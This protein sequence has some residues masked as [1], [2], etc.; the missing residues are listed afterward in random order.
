MK[1]LRK[2]GPDFAIGEEHLGQHRGHDVE[3]YLNVERPYTPFLR[4]PPYTARLETSEEIEKHVNELIDMDVIRQI[5]H[6]RIVEVT[7]ISLITWNVGKIRLCGDFR[8]QNN[9][10]KADKYPIQKIPHSL[11]ELATAKYITNMDCMR[12]FHQN[13]VD[14]KF[15]MSTPECLLATRLHQPTYKG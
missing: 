12:G 5:G 6:N 14:P 3:L 1:I 10:T 8:A 7:T 9:Y 13:G 2:K 4:R 11:E 15:Y